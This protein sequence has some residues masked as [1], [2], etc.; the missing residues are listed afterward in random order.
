MS[1]E[2]LLLIPALLLCVIVV[3]WLEHKDEELR[4]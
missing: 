3:W 1:I 2:N 4:P